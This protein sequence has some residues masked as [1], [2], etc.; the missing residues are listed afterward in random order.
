MMALLL[1]FTLAR[2]FAGVAVAGVLGAASLVALLLALSGALVASSIE[3][4]RQI[5]LAV[6]SANASHINFI[7]KSLLDLD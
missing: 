6:L 5:D 3:E 7:K 2:A 4:V 1:A